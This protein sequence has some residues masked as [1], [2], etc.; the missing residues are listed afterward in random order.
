MAGGWKCPLPPPPC[1]PPPTPTQLMNKEELTTLLTPQGSSHCSCLEH[2]FL[3][4]CSV[5]GGRGSL[6]RADRR[7]VQ[8]R[9]VVVHGGVV[10]IRAREPRRHRLPREWPDPGDWR[11]AEN[12]SHREL[13]S[14]FHNPTCRTSSVQTYGRTHMITSTP[15]VPRPA[16]LCF[17]WFLLGLERCVLLTFGSTLALCSTDGSCLFQGSFTEWKQRAPDDL[18]E[19]S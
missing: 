8:Q 14:R 6:G 12:K 1:P 2:C 3:F 19:R 11:V 7:D 9:D 18:V 16:R 5:R 13:E 15:E 17:E 4:C 10:R